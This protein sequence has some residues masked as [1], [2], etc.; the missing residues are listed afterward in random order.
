MNRPRIRHLASLALATALMSAAGPG[1]ALA[2]PGPAPRATTVTTHQAAL[3]F[4]NDGIF[5]GTV[6][7]PNRRAHATGGGY[8]LREDGH[9][10]ESRPDGNRSWHVKATASGIVYVRCLL[11]T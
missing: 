8:A 2:G 7:C 1:T 3:E 10:F 4:T 5:E 6:T 11:I 9:A